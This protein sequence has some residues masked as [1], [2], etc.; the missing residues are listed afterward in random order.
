MG[1]SWWR[2]KLKYEN[3]SLYNPQELLSDSQRR[4]EAVAEFGQR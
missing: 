4:F 3:I 1:K 2:M